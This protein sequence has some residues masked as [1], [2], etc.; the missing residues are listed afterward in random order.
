MRCARSHT[1]RIVRRVAAAM[2]LLVC[3]PVVAAQQ[4]V[5]L[6][7]PAETSVIELEPALKWVDVCGPAVFSVT[8]SINSSAIYSV[9]VYKN[10]AMTALVN[11]LTVPEGILMPGE[12]YN[13]SVDAGSHGIASASFH[14]LS[15]MRRANA[16][17][18]ISQGRQS[19]TGTQSK[20]SFINFLM[21]E[22]LSEMALKEADRL[23][24]DVMNGFAGR[25]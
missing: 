16:L 4:C 15:T 1:A 20:E 11:E 18:R 13:W 3:T 7:T 6:A 14:T 10:S 5:Y 9:V 19:G 21:M 12:H 2:V 22:G 8:L 24:Q 25:D 17:G 23:Q